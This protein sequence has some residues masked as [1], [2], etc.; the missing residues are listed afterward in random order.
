[1]CT[2]ASLLVDRRRRA[3]PESFFFSRRLA[4]AQEDGQVGIYKSSKAQPETWALE[5]V[6]DAG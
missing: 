1:M 3:Y 5:L 4:I 6:V 2:S